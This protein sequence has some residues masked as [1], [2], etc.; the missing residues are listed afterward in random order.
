MKQRMLKWLVP[1]ILLFLVAWTFSLT[2]VA[3]PGSQANLTYQDRGDRYE[4]IKG[5]PVSDRVELLSALVDYQE[6][7]KQIPEH[8]KM[9]F[10]LREQSRVFITVREIDNRRSYWMDRI[11]PSS[12]WHQGFGNEFAWPTQ[13][14]IRPL[15]DLQLSDLGAVAQLGSDD[16]SLDMR[17]APVIFFY[18]QLPR[19]IGRYSFTFKI[20]RR[21]DVA[22]SFSKDEDNSPVPSTQSFKMP[23]NRP[24]T[25]NWNA[26]NARE[27]WYRLKI[28][29]VYSNNGQELNQIL[30]FYHR[31]KI[32]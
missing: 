12:G 3:W 8:F 9:K 21:A 5:S 20:S 30:H 32:S 17:V 26:S 13:D 14:V 2:P 10:Y 18:S 22:C 15:K 31:P 29:V 16:P 28:N 25:V 1:A 11:R 7:Y 4:G 6:D 27:G 19:S 23:G 24:R